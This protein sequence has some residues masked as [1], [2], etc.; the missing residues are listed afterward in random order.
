MQWYHMC[1]VIP[2]SP[3]QRI[4]KPA[5]LA[6]GN[7]AVEFRRINVLEERVRELNSGIGAGLAAD[8]AMVTDDGD[9]DA[10]ATAAAKRLGYCRH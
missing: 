10:G 2:D 9:G 4:A 3:S 5:L 1:G 8:A 7:N 6:N